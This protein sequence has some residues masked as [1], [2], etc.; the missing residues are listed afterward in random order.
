MKST[1]P[2][3]TAQPDSAVSSARPE[4]HPELRR[5]RPRRVAAIEAGKSQ[6]AWIENLN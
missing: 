5:D 6:K 1:K 4:E 3:R 2:P